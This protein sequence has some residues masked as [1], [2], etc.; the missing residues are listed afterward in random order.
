MGAN[1]AALSANSRPRLHLKFRRSIK[2]LA[3]DPDIDVEQVLIQPCA[4]DFDA[5]PRLVGGRQFTVAVALQWRRDERKGN[6]LRR[7]RVLANAMIGE[8]SIGLQRCRQGKVRKA[9]LAE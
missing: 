5:E 2:R 1:A 9:G 7:S 8:P 3:A 6:G 4:V